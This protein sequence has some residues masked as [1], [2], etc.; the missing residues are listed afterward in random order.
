MG[1]EP[2]KL[3]TSE[4]QQALEA[5]SAELARAVAAVEAAEAHR[6]TEE[7]LAA[8]TVFVTGEGRS[9]LVARGFAMR[10]GQLGLRAYVVGETVAPAAAKGDL[11]LAISGSG[12]TR[13]TVTHAKTARSLGVRIAAVTAAP[14]SSLA[15][16]AGL[17]LLISGASVQYGGSLFEQA[18]LI[19]LDTLAL[20]LQHRLGQT[21]G[22]MDARHTNLE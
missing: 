11:L 3:D 20:I 1:N 21:A 2:P 12:E 4:S 15:R 13:V 18:A 5:I 6:L 17:Q 19:V 9:G 8:K 22:E 14:E 16:R 7:I 10:L